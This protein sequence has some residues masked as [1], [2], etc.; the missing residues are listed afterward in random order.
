M[1]PSEIHLIAEIFG[2]A[3]FVVLAGIIIFELHQNLKQ[4]KIQNTFMRNIELGK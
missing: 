3:V 4:R 1:D 2:A